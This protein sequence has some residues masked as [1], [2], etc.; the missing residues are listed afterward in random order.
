MSNFGFEEWSA[1]EIVGI[2][3]GIG[4]KRPSDHQSM[5]KY[6]SLNSDISWDYLRRTLHNQEMIG[7]AA[8]SLNDPFELSPNTFN[9]LQPSTIATA[10]KHNDIMERLSGKKPRPLHDVFPDSEPYRLQAISFLNSVTTQYRIISF[11][12]RAD[13]GLLWAHYANSYQGA[14][15]QFLAKGFKLKRNTLGY[16]SY[17]KHRPTY[18]LSLALSLSSKPGGPKIPMNATWLKRTESE[19]I[20]FFVKSNEWA[21]ES[22]IRLVY[23]HEITKSIRFHKDSFISIIT[24]PR[25]SDENRRRL[26]YLVK[27]SPCEGVVIRS[28]KLSKTTFSIEIDG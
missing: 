5:F 6:V 24:G 26:S 19:K 7:S 20:L 16:V 25:F 1:E 18:P 15:L 11:C 8:S 9:D 27:G 3:T 28:A 17:A 2:Q 4:L 12:E 22:E 23:D 10:V 21:Y 14:C 13:S